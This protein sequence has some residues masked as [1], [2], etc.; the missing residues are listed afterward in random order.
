MDEDVYQQRQDPA[1]TVWFELETGERMLAWTTTPWTLPTN[2]AM[3]VGPDID[4]VV[5]EHEGARWLL[6]RGAAPP[7]PRTWAGRA[8]QGRRRARR[9]SSALKGADLVG[10]RYAPLFDFLTDVERFG[11]QNAFQVILADHVTTTD[12]SGVVHMAPA[13][14]EDDQKACEAPGSPPS[15]R[16][17][18]GRGSRPS[19]RRTR[20]STSSRRTRRSPATCGPGRRAARGLYVHSYPHC[21]RCRNPLIYKAVSSW[22]V[23]VTKFRDR[24][25]ELNEQIDWTPEHVKHGQFGKWLANARDWSISRN[26]FWGSPIPVWMSDD[27]AYPRV[28]V[29]GSLDELEADFGVEA[30]RPAP[31]VRRRADPSEP[32]RPDRVARP[33]AGC[34]TCSTSGST[35]A[36]CPSRRCTTRSRTRDWFEHHYPGDFIVEYIAADARLV[37]HAARAGDRA[38]RP[39]GVPRVRVPR[40]RARRRR[41][42]DVQVAAATTPTSPRCS[43]ATAPTRC[44]GS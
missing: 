30:D 21:W 12:G 7:T 41:A 14:G 9:S 18:T 17:T 40:H 6:A 10:R 1:I 36:R 33:C 8:R 34:P 31:A 27:P 3:A 38:V 4:Y 35:R 44:A 39:S 37:L 26:R 11:T 25:V 19:C 28:D 42:E 23:E 2:E 24:M 13:Y 16:S 15:S 32:G 20:A 22:F 29:Y 43:T 5:V